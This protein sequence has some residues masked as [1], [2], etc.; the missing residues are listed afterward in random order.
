VSGEERQSGVINKKFILAIWILLQ[1]FRLFC[2]INPIYLKKQYL[3]FK[4]RL[5]LKKTI[6]L[7]IV[8]ILGN[9]HFIKIKWQ[10]PL[11]D[12]ISSTIAG[13]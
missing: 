2:I 13:L 9:E 6:L 4:Y 12:K 11:F 7:T 8:E 5:F 1:V 3:I 10:K